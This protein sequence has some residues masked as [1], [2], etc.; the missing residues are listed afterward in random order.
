M[1]PRDDAAFVAYCA[2]HDAIIAAWEALPN[3]RTDWQVY[4]HLLSEE[5]TIGFEGTDLDSND[6]STSVPHKAGHGLSCWRRSRKD[7]WHA[8]R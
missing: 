8:T 6:P 4:D 2:E 1:D 5:L 7:L 3:K